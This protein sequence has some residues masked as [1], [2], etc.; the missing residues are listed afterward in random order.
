MKIIHTSDWHLGHRLYNYDRTDEE[1]HFF[2]QLAETVRAENPDVL[3]AAGDIFHSGVPGNDVAKRFTDRLLAV[4]EACPDMETVLIAGNHDS[5]S[6]LVVDRALWSRFRVHVF[7]VPA[8]DGEGRAVFRRNVV[9]IPGKGVVAAVPF[10]HSRNV[11]VVGDVP[12]GDRA[13][14]YFAGLAEYAASRADGL[15]TV[16]VAHLAVAG[17]LDLRGHDRSRLVGGEESLDVGTLGAAWDYVALGHIHCPQW[18]RGGR[19]RARYC[20]SPR[21]IHFDEAYPHGVDVVTVG[22]GRE[23]EA[24]TVAFEPK[25]PLATLGGADGQPFEEALATVAGATLAPETYVRLNVR[26]APGELP[27]PDWTERARRA[28]AARNLRFCLNHP[29]RAEEPAGP[30]DAVALTVAKLKELSDDEVV[31][32]L[33]ARHELTARHRELMRS[34]MRD[35]GNRDE[36]QNT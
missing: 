16:L 22:A 35:R 32:I 4:Q 1:E 36:N 10:C 12:E 31:A 34:L 14:R 6:R 15:P 11:P 18:I 28:C 19:R 2:D 29:V 21:A 13:A 5:Y 27:L 3:V 7:G 25:R 17:E 26:L 33:S 20:G 8:E 9:E 23:P 24:R 30:A